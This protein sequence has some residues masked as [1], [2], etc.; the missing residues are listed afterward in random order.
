MNAAVGRPQGKVAVE[1]GR[2]SEDG[3]IL[4]SPAAVCDE[5]RVSGAGG[6][7][8][9]PGAVGRP[10]KLGHAFKVWP[11]L[12]AQCRHRPDA[13]VAAARAVGPANPKGDERVH[14]ARTPGF[15]S[16]D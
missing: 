12:A 2:R 4:R 7:V 15:G 9:E 14:R 3:P 11:R 6:V 5:Q 1:P 16:M 13:N 8:R 10:V